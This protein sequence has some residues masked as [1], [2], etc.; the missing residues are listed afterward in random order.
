[1]IFEPEGPIPF[2]AKE[3]LAGVESVILGVCSQLP[4]HLRLFLFLFQLLLLNFSLAQVPT[5]M[6][7]PDGSRVSG[8]PSIKVVPQCPLL[9]LLTCLTEKKSER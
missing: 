8:T 9:R 4:L 2:H 3:T 7:A 6:P 5:L 1:M